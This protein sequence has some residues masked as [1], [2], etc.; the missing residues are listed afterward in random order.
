[1]K[2]AH[3][4]ILGRVQGVWFREETK[5]RALDLG[6]T[7]WVRNKQDGN[8]EA[9]FEGPENKINEIIEWCKKGPSLSRVDD[10]KIEFERY[11]GDFEDFKITI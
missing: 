2:R 7:G 3:V 10:V 9:V 11:K 1:M 6:L 8:V 4:I 5:K